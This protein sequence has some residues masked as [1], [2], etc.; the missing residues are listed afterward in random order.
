VSFKLQGEQHI[1]LVGGRMRFADSGNSN[2]GHNSNSEKL[3]RKKIQEELL[4]EQKALEEMVLETIKKG[5]CNLG[6]NASILEQSGK[7]DK[8]IV[9]EMILRETE[10]IDTRK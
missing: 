10:E 2:S 6:E 5:D 1:S 8:L 7:L 9:D 4:K 3:N